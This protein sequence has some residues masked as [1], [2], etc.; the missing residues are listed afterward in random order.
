MSLEPRTHLDSKRRFTD[1]WIGRDKKRLWLSPLNSSRGISELGYALDRHIYPDTV[2]SVLD[3]GTYDGEFLSFARGRYHNAPKFVG[4]ELSPKAAEEAMR[5]FSGEDDVSIE[6]REAGEYLHSTPEG[7]D[8]VAFI[9]FIQ[10][11]D[12]PE[13]IFEGASRVLNSGGYLVATAPD[14]D[15]VGAVERLG[16]GNVDQYELPS[17]LVISRITFR[18][19][20]DGELLEWSQVGIPGDLV[21][22]NFRRNGLITVENGSRK[23]P[24][25]L[26]PLPD[27]IDILY[28]S[29]ERRVNLKDGVQSFIRAQESYPNRGPTVPLYMARKP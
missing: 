20:I 26:S 21:I 11:A 2:G 1:Y 8:I 28:E 17:G 25:S 19:N 3:V 18:F 29:E 9:N 14:Q 22:D 15:S 5:R 12:N 24:V 4:I 7:F 16:L 23:L 27:I 13:Y 6:N 10:D